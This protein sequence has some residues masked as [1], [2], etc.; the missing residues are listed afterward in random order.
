MVGAVAL[1]LVGLEAGAQPVAGQS[2]PQAQQAIPD[3]PRPQLGIGPVAPGK[4]TTL[5]SSSTD[6][7]PAAGADNSV[8]SSLPATPAEAPDSDPA[9]TVPDVGQGPE[10]FRLNVRVNFVEVP[11]IVKDNKGRLVPGITPR[12]VRIYENG[13][14]MSPKVFTTD[15]FPMSVALVIDQSLD[16]QTMARVNNALGALPAAFAPYDEVAVFTYNNGPRL[17]TDFTGG[18]SARLAAVIDRTKTTGRD[19]LYYDTGGVGTGGIN[20]NNGDNRF[21]SPLGAETGPGSP[22]GVQQVPREVHTLNDAILMAA[23]ALSKAKPGR[24]RIIYVISDGKEYGSVAKTKEV[25][26]ILETNQVQVFATLTGDSSVEGLGFIDRLHV[27]LMMRDN[28]LKAY[29]DATGGQIFAEFRTKAIADSFAKVTEQVRTQYTIGYVSPEPVVDGKFRTLEVKIARP[30]L[31][32]IAKN[33]Y[34]PSAEPL[35]PTGP[36]PVR[37]APPANN[38]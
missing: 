16:F 5:G 24:R 30:N 37:T 32:V 23:Q 35:R 15:P 8:P 20:Y 11:F 12:D 29:T 28:N 34:Y 33:G 21:A 7:V 2:A 36:A 19:P 31:Q 38:P 18:Q 22:R 14:R 10:A 27:P 13:L 6:T 1:M 25:L 3:A 17:Q 4:G 26:R 9:P